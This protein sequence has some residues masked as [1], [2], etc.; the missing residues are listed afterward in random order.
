MFP[1]SHDACHTW[2]HL[3]A[4]K[5]M[6]RNG[7]M[8]IRKTSEPKGQIW[9]AHRR[10]GYKMSQQQSYDNYIYCHNSIWHLE[11][12]KTMEHNSSQ[13]HLPTLLKSQGTSGERIHTDLEQG[14][15]LH[16][17]RTNFGRWRRSWGQAHGSNEDRPPRLVFGHTPWKGTTASGSLMRL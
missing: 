6:K 3:L 8:P 1:K 16:C 11:L 7:L 9:K 2:G 17:N 13:I 5:S 12:Q 4:F 14:Q 15:V 10:G